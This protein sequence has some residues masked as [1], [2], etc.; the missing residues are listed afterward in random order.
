MLGPIIFGV[1]VL[2]FLSWLALDIMSEIRW[3]GRQLRDQER[4]SAMDR[5]EYGPHVRAVGTPGGVYRAW[6]RRCDWRIRNENRRA[7]V[8][9][10]QRHAKE[11]AR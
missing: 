11:H 1:C 8:I 6:C 10:C 4:G 2:L 5:L 7:L 9:A 3:V